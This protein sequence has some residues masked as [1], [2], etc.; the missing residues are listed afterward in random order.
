MSTRSGVAVTLVLALATLALPAAAQKLFKYK[1]ANGVWVFTDRQPEGDQQY[2][3]AKVEHSFDKPDV[4]LFERSEKDGVTL[5]AQN[6]Y[7][8]PIQLAYRITTAKTSRTDTPLRGMQMLPARGDRLC[9]ASARGSVDAGLVRL[10]VPVPPRRSA[11]STGQSSHTD[12]RSANR[13]V[14][15]LA[16]VSR[17]KSRTPSRRARRDRLRDADRHCTSMRHA[18]AS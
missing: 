5:Y 11:Q 9:S 12:S 7:Y 4:R 6:T 3:T 13:P 15:R 2:E 18:A 10:R 1:D 14:L 16:G 17:N 8:A